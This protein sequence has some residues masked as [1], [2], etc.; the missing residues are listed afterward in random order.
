MI[1][2]ATNLKVGRL[3]SYAAK[4]SLAGKEITIVN[5]EKS[6]ITGRKSNI[7]EN[8]FEKRRVGSRYHGPY[9]PKQSDRILKR[10]I[11]GMLP[12]KKKSGREALKKIKVYLG[13][14][15]EF[16]GKEYAKVE[17]AE[18]GTLQ[19]KNYLELGKLSKLIGGND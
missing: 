10:A 6:V 18:A 12:Y 16:S 7:L 11:R 19:R 2:D 3:A 15:E 17:V 13:V 5:A 9:Y 8:Y 1:I 14:P 4:E